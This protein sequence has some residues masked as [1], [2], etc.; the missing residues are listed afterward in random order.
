MTRRHLAQLCFALAAANAGACGAGERAAPRGPALN[1]EL[2]NV[3][4]GEV[5]IA[6]YRGRVLVLHVFATWADGAL[7]DVDQLSALYRRGDRCIAMV[8]IAVDPEGYRL[9]GPWRRSLK[10]PYVLTVASDALR[11]G[12]TPLGRVEAVPT[13]IL[14]DPQGREAVRIERALGPGE[15]AR[16]VGKLRRDCQF[17][18]HPREPP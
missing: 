16:E 7:L 17:V 13:T 4:G 2:S 9:V 12:Q 8:G 1:L 6:D 15:L 5:D 10:I 14:V 11:A 18:S 3:D